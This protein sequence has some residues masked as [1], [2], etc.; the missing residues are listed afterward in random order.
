MHFYFSPLK[1]LD[2]WYLSTNP[3]CPNLLKSPYLRKKSWNWSMSS[4]L[5]YG[6]HNL[7]C[8]VLG[9]VSIIWCWLI[10]HLNDHHIMIN[11]IPLLL[12][13]VFYWSNTVYN[14]KWIVWP[15]QEG[16]EYWFVAQFFLLVSICIVIHTIK[17]S[18]I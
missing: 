11:F 13:F 10:S 16:K 17:Q 12:P 5:L 6:K 4:W 7:Q 1:C 8:L 14:S 15:L 18:I 2:H 3:I 9:Q